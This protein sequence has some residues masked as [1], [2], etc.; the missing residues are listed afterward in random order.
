MSVKKWRGGLN[1]ISNFEGMLSFAEDVKAIDVF[2]TMSSKMQQHVAIR[3]FVLYH[4]KDMN[5][6][7]EKYHGRFSQFEL[8]NPKVSAY[9]IQRTI[10]KEKKFKGVIA[11]IPGKQKNISRFITVS[12]T[13]FWEYAV[14]RLAKRILYPDAI[15]VYFKQ[16]E[17]SEAFHHLEASLPAGHSIYLSDVTS[18]QKRETQENLKRENFDTHRYWTDTPWRNVFSRA[19]ED[20]QWFTSLKFKIKKQM[21]R[22][23]VT[24][25]SGKIYKQGEIHFD[26]FYELLNEAFVSYLE[27]KA[28]ERLSLL[29]DRG[30][31]ERNYQP[32][33]PIEISFDFNAFEHVEDVREFG[34]IMSGYPNSAKAVYHGNP[35]YHANIADF[36][37]GSSFEIWVLSTDKIMIVPQAR[38]SAEAFERLISYIFTK[39][40]EGKVNEYESAH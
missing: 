30:I 13:G 5:D 17:I 38:S 11:I 37:D 19:N 36:K 32:S 22:D 26:Y 25:A 31:I 12:L 1:P 40:H 20:N 8:I 6:I 27:Q 34:K 2:C 3:Q 4:R 35:Y 10:N 39:F 9:K 14:R 21:K 15:P 29:E 28:S 18:R 16:S 33:T 7:L 23:N 24:V